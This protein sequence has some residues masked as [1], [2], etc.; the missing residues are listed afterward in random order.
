MHTTIYIPNFKKQCKVLMPNK[1]AYK[2]GE[3]RGLAQRIHL[4]I[5]SS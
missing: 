2:D 4:A 3:K 1:S 5:A